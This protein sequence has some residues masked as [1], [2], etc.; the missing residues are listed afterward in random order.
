MTQSRDIETRTP[1]TPFQSLVA[2][3]VAGAAEAFITHPFWALKVRSQRNDSFTLN[4]RLLYRGIVPNVC[5]MIP[6]TA[7]QLGLDS[8]ASNHF[9]WGGFASA[10]FAGAGA[11]MVCCP[12]EMIM[13]YQSKHGGSLMQAAD[14][15][16]IQGGVRALYNGF[17]VTAA[18]ESIFTTSLLFLSPL[19]KARFQSS[20]PNEGSASLAA[21][22][23]SGL[24]ATYAS[25]GF[26]T[27]KTLQQAANPSQKLNV[28]E[29]ARQVF[30]ND[31]AAGFFRGSGWRCANVSAAVTIIADVKDR[32]EKYYGK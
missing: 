3:S 28:R 14:A 30:K 21:G 29:T 17:L 26:D 23:L 2:G 4:P 24:T 18:R 19:L 22:L 25:H 8:F 31:G 6:I 16:I 10:L 5:S 32:V 7:V 11:S 20:L 27:I 15:I 9:H 13:T 1:L 12:T